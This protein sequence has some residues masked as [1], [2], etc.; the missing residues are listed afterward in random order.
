MNV[1]AVSADAA[2][3]R[4]TAAVSTL[5]VHVA[6]VYENFKDSEAKLR[7]RITDRMSQKVGEAYYGHAEPSSGMVRPKFYYHGKS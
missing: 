5:E 1:Y 3:F 7:Y 6:Y 2:V 4:A